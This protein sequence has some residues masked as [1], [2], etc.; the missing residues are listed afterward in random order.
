MW[1]G[2]CLAVVGALW[3]GLALAQ[4][5]VIEGRVDR[6]TDGDSVWL[7]PATGPRVEVR[8]LGI[9][10]PEGCQEWGPESRRALEAL[11]LGRDARVQTKGRDTHGRTLGT[12]FVDGVNLNQRQVE[13]GHAWSMRFKW[14]QGPY[15]KQE[16]MAKALNRGL[17]ASGGAVMPRDFRRNHGPCQAGERPSRATPPAPTPPAPAA[18]PPAAPAAVPPAQPPAAANTPFRC[19]GRTRC[20]QMRSCEEATFFL[21][22]CPGVQMD[23]DGNGIP[24]ESQFCRRP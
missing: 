4:A 23:G 17:F 11:A 19:D 8:L 21:K 22:N 24:C 20:S 18:R 16:R 3:A 15:V 1:R 13:E 14:D 12:L 10:A 9:D 5:A 6:V 7:A 2:L